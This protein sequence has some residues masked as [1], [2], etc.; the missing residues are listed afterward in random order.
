MLVWAMLLKIMSV[1]MITKL[2]SFIIQN[3]SSFS[4][5][6]SKGV[7]RQVVYA[8]HYKTNNK[9]TCKIFKILV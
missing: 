6:G 9:L 7:K 2:T 3:F 4:L 5:W 8:L 1:M